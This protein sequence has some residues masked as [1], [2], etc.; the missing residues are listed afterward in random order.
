MIFLLSPRGGRASITLAKIES[1]ISAVEKIQ[2]NESSAQWVDLNV[3]SIL[4]K[5]LASMSGLLSVN[6]FRKMQNISLSTDT[7]SGWLLSTCLQKI[8]FQGLAVHFMNSRIRGSHYALLFGKKETV[9]FR[10][11]VF[12]P[13]FLGNP[14]EKQVSSRTLLG[15]TVPWSLC[16]AFST[17]I[18]GFSCLDLHIYHIIVLIW[19]L[20]ASHQPLQIKI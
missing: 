15:T 12:P 16:D 18:L 13:K 9:K 19:L 14:K 7:L 4:S 11:C 20:R 2:V 6:D 8:I 3:S 1:I 5:F 10:Y 17:L